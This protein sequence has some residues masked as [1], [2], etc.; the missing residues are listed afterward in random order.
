V[1]GG[2]SSPSVVAAAADAGIGALF[3]SEPTV[4]VRSAGGCLVFGRFAI[5][6]GTSAATVERLVS[7][8]PLPRVQQFTSWNTKKLA[9][10][11]GGESY[12]AVRRALL[13]SR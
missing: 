4:R 9:K 10:A 8:D 5:L 1:A 13:R 3:T 12:L 11:V 2:Y 6:H 7:G